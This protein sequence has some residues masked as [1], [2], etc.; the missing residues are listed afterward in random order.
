VRESTTALSAA[1]SKRA[2][3]IREKAATLRRIRGLIN[4][5]RLETLDFVSELMCMENSERI[6]C[7][8]RF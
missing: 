8:P 2:E 3:S 7:S 4:R 5:D 1:F 6:S